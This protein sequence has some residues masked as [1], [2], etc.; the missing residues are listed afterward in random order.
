MSRRTP[1]AK[2]RQSE[3]RSST[4]HFRTV[5]CCYLNFSKLGGQQHIV[6][7]RSMLSWVLEAEHDNG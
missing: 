5:L 4:L 3:E 7:Y 6:C 2:V 1:R